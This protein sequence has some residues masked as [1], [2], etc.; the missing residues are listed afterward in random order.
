MLSK[1][2]FVLAV[3]SALLIT[4][5]NDDDPVNDKGIEDVIE[6][7]ID[8]YT[9]LDTSTD[10]AGLWVA[11]GTGTFSRDDSGD[12]KYGEQ[13][14][15]IYFLIRGSTGSYKYA[16]CFDEGYLGEGFDRGGFEDL[17]VTGDSVVFDS[18]DSN[19]NLS[20]DDG[21]T[22][23]VG[24]VSDNSEINTVFTFNDGD[25]LETNTFRMIK[26][27]NDGLTAI[28]TSKFE[29][30]GEI[31]V[32]PAVNCF[33]QWNGSYSTSDGYYTVNQYDASFETVE[34]PFTTSEYLSDAEDITEYEVLTY[35]SSSNRTS[36]NTRN[37]D[38]I[39]LYFLMDTLGFGAYNSG[40]AD[41]QYIGNINIS[42]PNL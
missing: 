26:V 41:K 24:T 37:S 36:M 39:S 31:D 1:L 3:T 2:P 9:E 12:R 18:K 35:G 30:S 17:E 5:C 33:A 23:N 10:L 29:E 14:A 7:N 28:G 19:D 11:V 16:N 4:G 20:S 32:E 22:S 21:D 40:S 13:S 27:S 38:F 8:D 25:S 6:F 34:D 42:H 15:K